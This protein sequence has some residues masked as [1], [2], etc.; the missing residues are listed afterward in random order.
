MRCNAAAL[1]HGSEHNQRPDYRPDIDGLRGV[2]I[3][4]VVVYHLVPNA[5]PAGFLGVDVFFVISGFL[6]STIIFKSLASDGFSFIEFYAHR[7]RRLFPALIIVIGFCLVV[8]WHA[9]LPA[10]FKMLASHTIASSLYMENFRLSAEAGYF[11]VSTALKP[12]MHLWSLGIEE[13]FYLVFPFMMW[14]GWR[15]RLNLFVLVAVIFSTSLGGFLYK[16][17]S[18]P[19]AAFF[20][21]Q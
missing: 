17:T 11:D 9:L 7:I 12:L 19:V 15:L 2:A 20:F 10:E 6:I 3:L 16:A 18:W 13:Q 8:G 14:F 5:V 4:S 1:S 21:T